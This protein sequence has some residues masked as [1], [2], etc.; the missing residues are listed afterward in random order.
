MQS[1][2]I[3][4]NLPD[5]AR[6]AVI[7]IGNFDGMHLGHQALLAGAKQLARSLGKDL[8]V[9]TFEPHPRRLFRPD[10]PPFRLTSPQVKAERIQAAGADLLFSASFDWDFASL[11]ADQFISQILRGRLGAAHI[12]IGDDFRFGQLRK[13]SVETLQSA[14]LPATVIDKVSSAGGEV[15]SSSLIRQALGAGEIDRANRLLGWPWEMRGIVRSGDRRGRELGFPTANM[16]LGNI[17]HPSY[18]IYAAQ[19]QIMED[20]SDSPWLP[21]AVNIGIRPMFA[22]SEGQ[23]EAHILDFDRDIYGKTLRVRPVRRL[24]GEAKFDSLDALIRQIAQDCAEVRAAL[25][26]ME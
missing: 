8:G 4:K 16:S 7:A 12:V 26:D 9:L 5:S 6:G 21:S 11:S 24:R 19:A 17:L 15:L 10:D 22:L 20:G 13:G 3:Y 18:G 25:K 14:G 2:D 1:F 23:V